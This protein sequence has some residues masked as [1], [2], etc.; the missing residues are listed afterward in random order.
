METGEK[1]MEMGKETVSDEV[2]KTKGLVE[3][4]KILIY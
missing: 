4:G 2:G 1:T 3:S